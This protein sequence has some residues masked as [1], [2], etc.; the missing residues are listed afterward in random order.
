M[1]AQHWAS[2]SK[3][4][5]C[6]PACF[7][8]PLSAVQMGSKIKNINSRLEKLRQQRS[9]EISW[10]WKLTF[11][12]KNAIPLS[13]KRL[14]IIYC[15]ELEFLK[16]LSV[17]LLEY[18]EIYLCDSL[19]CIS[20]DGPLPETIS[21]LDIQSCKALVTLSSSR[22]EYL[23]KALTSIFI[24][25]CEKLKSIGESF[26]NSPCLEKITLMD[27]KNVESLPLGLHHLP[28][29]ELIEIK[30]CPKLMA[31]EGV[32]TSLRQLLI[33]ECEDDKGMGMGMLT[34]L[35][36]LRIEELPQLKSISDLTNLTSLERLV[37]DFLPQ[38]ESVPE[39]NNLNSLKVFTIQGLE[40]IPN[41]SSL[42][43]LTELYIGYCTE[44][45][46][47]SILN[48]LTSLEWLV[49]ECLPQLES[50]QNP[51]NLTSL[52][53]FGIKICAR[54]KSIPNLSSL[55][56]HGRLDIV[57]C[58]RLKSI[59][60][61]GNFPDLSIKKCPKL[62]SLK[63][64][65]S[66]LQSLDIKDCPLLIKRLKSVTGRYSSK[67]A[68]IPKVEIDGKFIYNSKEYI[69]DDRSFL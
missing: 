37:I 62:K 7:P 68:Q 65:P 15:W 17:C 45:E 36:R 13:I 38:L 66:S 39:L 49:I 59:P 44:L 51:S 18:L 5:S 26:N 32:P 6:L 48:G 31:R 58:P 20:V 22:N 53:H 63:T 14:K 9:A 54:L 35:K 67:I 24:W 30:E 34:S 25:G 33:N 41:F 8:S 57:D 69:V 64:L 29:L 19:K 12:S 55:A 28:C 60:D 50:I 3:G 43:S 1:K 27:C 2:S 56:S 52:R 21:Q 4:L 11:I 47:M 46:S 61:L 42:T 10:C 16:D 23:P 40:R